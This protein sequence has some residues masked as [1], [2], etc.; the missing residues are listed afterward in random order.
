M[1][2]QLSTDELLSTTRTVRKRLDFQRPVPLEVVRECLELAIQAPTGSNSQGW[3]WVVVT[4]PGK[5]R[6]LGELYR[7]GF[8]AY[9][10]AAH[11]PGRRDTGD[12]DAD[13][14]G[15]RV[16]SSAEYLAER[17]GQA[18]VLLIP[19]LGNRV[20]GASSQATASYWGSLFPAVWSFCL[21]AR[22]RGLGTAWTTLHLSYEREAAEVLGIPY[23][24]VSQGAMLPVAYTKG[25]DFK[26]A[27]RKDL[28]AILHIDGW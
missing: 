12:P 10:A 2:V 21:A 14:V 28:D 13:A 15:K 1:E 20:D 7:K 16:A 26:P 23:E 11:Y 8:Q 3:Q 22:S 17:M 27:P 25:T 4:D 5:R 24:K 9:A 19:C 6:E 18:P